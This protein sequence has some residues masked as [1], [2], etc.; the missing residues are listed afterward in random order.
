MKKQLISTFSLCLI[1]I[2]FLN[3]AFAQKQ[4][5]QMLPSVT[6]TASSL[7][8]RVLKSFSRLYD[9]ASNVRWLQIEDRYLVKFDQNDMK[10][11]AVY[12]KGGY[13][14]YHVGYG[15]EKNLPEDIKSIVRSVYDDYSFGSV[16][17]VEQ[18]DRRMW[19]VNLLNPKNII[20]ARIE[21]GDL[22]E[23]ARLQNSSVLAG[24]PTSMSKKPR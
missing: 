14:V 13:L 19:I 21:N 23:I 8:D 4:D 20:T 16:F 18:S 11:N 6:I 24:S 9:D 1:C 7:P 5:S 15:F 12:L 22:Q 10:H 2:L 3:R 17:D